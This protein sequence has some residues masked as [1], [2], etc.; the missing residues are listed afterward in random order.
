MKNHEGAIQDNAEVP[1]LCDPDSP[2]YIET[3]FLQNAL[4]LF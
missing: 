2:I 4:V 1:I 3:L